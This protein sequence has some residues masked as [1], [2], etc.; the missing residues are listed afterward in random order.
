MSEKTTEY[1]ISYLDFK[2]AA[3]DRG[4][5]P[6]EPLGVIVRNDGS[7]ELRTILELTPKELEDLKN[8]ERSLHIGIQEA[9]EWEMDLVQ[10][11]TESA[12][13]LDLSKPEEPNP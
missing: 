1:S 11:R 6:R 2:A 8:D 12:S 13:R 5:L 7:S 3:L 4:K 10:G 9:K